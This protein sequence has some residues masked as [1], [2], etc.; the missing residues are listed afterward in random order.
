MC[1]CV[2]VCVCVCRHYPLAPFPIPQSLGVGP[3]HAQPPADDSRPR[4]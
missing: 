1:V 2:C 4:V 3:T